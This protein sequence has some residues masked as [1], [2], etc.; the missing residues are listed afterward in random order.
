LEAVFDSPEFFP[1]AIAALRDD[2]TKTAAA[3]VLAR[4]AP[5][6]PGAVADAAAWEKW[7]Q[8]NSPY[9]FYSELGGYRWYVDPLA[10][11]R[12]VPSKDL[13]GPLRADVNARKF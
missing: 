2:K 6:G 13:R 4:Y 8:E 11:K 7:W 9:L 1:K 12:G 5:E 3:N 10:K